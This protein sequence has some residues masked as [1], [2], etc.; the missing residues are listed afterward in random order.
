MTKGK[1]THHC[2]HCGQ[3][4]SQQSPVAPFAVAIAI[5]G[6]ESIPD[7]VV[8]EFCCWDCVAM[9]FNKPVGEILEFRIQTIPETKHESEPL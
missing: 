5:G 1:F 2:N 7:G 6:P 3:Q 9:W 8:A 4:I